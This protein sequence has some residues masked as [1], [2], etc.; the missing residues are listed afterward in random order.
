MGLPRLIRLSAFVTPEVGKRAKAIATRYEVPAIYINPELSTFYQ[1]NSALT[2]LT[3]IPNSKTPTFTN[4]DMWN[5][6]PDGGWFGAQGGEVSGVVIAAGGG[7]AIG[8]AVVPSP[9]YSR[10]SYQVYFQNH[11][12]STTSAVNNTRSMG[13]A[14]Y[15]QDGSGY[16]EFTTYIAVGNT[17]Q[18]VLATLRLA[19]ETQ[20]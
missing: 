8:C 9:T 5:G 18:E 4:S 2:S 7:K 1:A 20:P 17:P 11:Q 15:V 3:Q 6:N 13:A 14:V 10:I 19:M 16:V 12:I